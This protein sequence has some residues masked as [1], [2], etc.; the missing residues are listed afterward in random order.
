MGMLLSRADKNS[1]AVQT[2]RWL[3]RLNY[4]YAEL[5]HRGRN[6]MVALDRA[7]DLDHGGVRSAA[8]NR[9]VALTR[10]LARTHSRIRAL[11]HD[12]SHDTILIS[13]LTLDLAVARDLAGESGLKELAVD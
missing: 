10:S 6:L 4:L 1:S 7:L 12:H 8:L 2:A 11:D 3:E 5:Y 9:A 13:N